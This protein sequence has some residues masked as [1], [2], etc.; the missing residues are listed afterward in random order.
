MPGVT[1]GMKPVQE[2]V[3]VA[4]PEGKTWESFAAKNRG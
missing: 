2:G 3:R 4:L 1:G